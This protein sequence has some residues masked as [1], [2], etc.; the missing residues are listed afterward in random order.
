[1][2]ACADWGRDGMPVPH[3][4]SHLTVDIVITTVPGVLEKLLPLVCVS[5]YPVVSDVATLA[6]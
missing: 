5:C 4:L 6:G 3:E 1:M 2:R